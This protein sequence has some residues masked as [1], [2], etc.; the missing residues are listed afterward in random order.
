MN[1]KND[2]NYLKTLPKDILIKI[3]TEI[4]E[5]NLK[6]REEWFASIAE[7]SNMKYCNVCY[8]LKTEHDRCFD[9]C[10]KCELCL[11]DDCNTENLFTFCNR[12]S[13]DFCLKCNI[14]NKCYICNC[15]L[16]ENCE[17]KHVHNR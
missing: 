12:C 15:N 16:C 2:Y 7:K 1:G 13:V 3:L 9:S 11:C 10:S 8:R 14:M 5:T 6:E 17:S 4:N